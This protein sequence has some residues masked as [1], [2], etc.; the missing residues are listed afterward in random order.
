MRRADIHRYLARLEFTGDEAAAL[1]AAPS[2][3]ALIELHRAHVRHVPYETL[4]FQLGRP[5]SIDPRAAAAR[6]IEGR[7]GYC[8]MLNGAFWALLMALGYDVRR[9]RGG[10]Q[11]RAEPAPVGANANH[12][13]LTVHGLPDDGALS[14]S[15]LVDVGLGDALYE[16]VPLR[17]GRYRQ[18]PFTYELRPSDVEPDGWRLDHDPAGSFAGMDLTM[19]PASTGDFLAMHRRL[20]TSPDSSFVRLASV[21]RRH[22]DGVD[23][24]RGCALSNV[25]GARR[26]ERILGSRIEW[27]QAL[28]DVFGLALTDLTDDDRARLWSSVEAAHARWSASK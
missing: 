16:P 28:A 11:G 1:V 26:E 5:A 23:L 25:A 20:S 27:F 19:A 14:G 17:P 21:Q 15:W 3:A 4:D 2:A 8:F 12:L 6:V 13:A 22:R 9:H 7:G 18:G 24:L 10:V